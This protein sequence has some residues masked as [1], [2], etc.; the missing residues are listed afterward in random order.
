VVGWGLFGPFPGG[1][2]P[3]L[4]PEAALEFS[5]DR[6]RRLDRVTRLAILGARAALQRGR[7]PENHP[8]RDRCGVF[9][10]NA[11][12]AYEANLEHQR[13]ILSHGGRSASPAAFTNT[14]PN[15]ASGWISISERL[16]G[17]VAT[18]AGGPLATGEAVASAFVHLQTGLEDLLLAGGAF[19]YQ[20]DVHAALARRRN[21]P[22]PPPAEI[23]AFLLLSGPTT[24]T[25]AVRL[26]GTGTAR[27][28]GTPDP[29]ARAIRLSGVRPEAVD[30]VLVSGD[31]STDEETT[32]RLHDLGFLKTHPTA[33]ILGDTAEAAPAVGAVLAAQWLIGEWAPPENDHSPRS[34]LVTGLDPCSRRSFALHF[35]FETGT[36]E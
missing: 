21:H 18:F 4:A 27:A 7:L 1:A 17:P 35:R 36:R 25:G 34:V 32:S 10:G 26:C 24:S 6:F 9:L 12:G 23:A 19:A 33:Q 15:V 8:N 20:E 31:P 29:L 11:Y 2:G 13:Q 14:L 28:S 3:R 16:K 5:D 30:A 22:T